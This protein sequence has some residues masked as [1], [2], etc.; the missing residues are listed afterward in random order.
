MLGAPPHKNPTVKGNVWWCTLWELADRPEFES[1]GNNRGECEPGGQYFHTLQ[2]IN[3]WTYSFWR[4][5]CGKRDLIPK[6]SGAKINFLD[7]AKSMDFVRFG[8]VCAL[9]DH[10]GQYENRYR[11]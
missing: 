1:P 6:E 11:G 5:P 3:R 2:L 7:L 4:A 9:S 8:H 10:W